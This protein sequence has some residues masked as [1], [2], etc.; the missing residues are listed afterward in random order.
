MKIG[1][2]NNPL[3]FAVNYFT[4]EGRSNRENGRIEDGRE[5]IGHASEARFV[6]Q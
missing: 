1:S 5:F 3:Q 2:T 4:K 6:I